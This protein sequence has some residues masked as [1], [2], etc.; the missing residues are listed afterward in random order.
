MRWDC[1]AL[2]WEGCGW[3]S[4]GVGLGFFSVAY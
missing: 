1:G 4:R 3:E 2:G